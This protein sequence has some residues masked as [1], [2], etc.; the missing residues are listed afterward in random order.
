MVT[1]CLQG[2]ES[3]FISEWLH[4]TGVHAVLFNLRPAFACKTLSDPFSSSV[5]EVVPRLSLDISEDKPHVRSGRGLIG[6]RSG[7]S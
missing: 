6:G 1:V 7:D 2:M 4:A 3:H 5:P